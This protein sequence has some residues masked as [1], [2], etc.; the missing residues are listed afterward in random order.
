[1]PGQDIISKERELGRRYARMLR[2][3]FKSQISV[4]QKHTGQTSKVG[5]RVRFRDLMLQSIAVRTTKVPFIN[6]FG[7]DKERKSHSFHSKSGAVLVRKAHP[8]KLNP[9]I[10]D[11]N[12]PRHIVDGFADELSELRGDR[13]MVDAGKLLD[14]K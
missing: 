13:I 2:D 11:L 7:V 6:Y 3:S 12:I 5:Y 9:K 10:S 1:M 14:I 4:L 8:F